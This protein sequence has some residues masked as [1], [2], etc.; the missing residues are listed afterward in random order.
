MNELVEELE[1]RGCQIFI[2]RQ[3]S[4][5]VESARSGVV[6]GGTPDIIV[7][8]PDGRTMIYDAKTGQESASHIAQVQ[9]YMYLLPKAHGM[10][11][12]AEWSS[13]AWSCTRAAA[14]GA[15]PPT[16]W[17]MPS[18]RGWLSSCGR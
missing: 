10:A 1:E 5:R 17:T 9:L 6:V 16:A 4:F 12:G 18:S 7:V 8:H 3:N 2:E 14:S 11:A 13:R 15:S